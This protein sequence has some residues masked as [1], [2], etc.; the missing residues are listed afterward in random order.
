M[1]LFRC[2]ACGKCYG[3]PEKRIGERRDCTC[4]QRQKV[5]RRSGRSA[6][7]RTWA[8]FLVETLVYGLGGGVLGFC[9]GALIVSQF[10][11]GLRRSWVILAG[12]AAGGLLFGGL[13]GERAI[14]W[15]GQKIRDRERD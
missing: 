10:G 2:S 13:G 14:N 3:V 7:Y 5:P 8:D 4:G 11:L 1:I 12:L 9:L 6:K 15:I